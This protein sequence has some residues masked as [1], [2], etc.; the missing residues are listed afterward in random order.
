MTAVFAF[1]EV[2]KVVEGLVQILEANLPVSRKEIRLFYT[3]P[4]GDI[5]IDTFP[6]NWNLG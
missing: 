5:Y 3:I 4:T 1:R 2:V 6:Q